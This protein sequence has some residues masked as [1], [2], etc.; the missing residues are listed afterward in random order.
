MDRFQKLFI[1]V[2]TLVVLI[3]LAILVGGKIYS[4]WGRTLVY[5]RE[6]KITKYPG[7]GD[8]TEKLDE[9]IFV[10]P[11]F[12]GRPYSDEGRPFLL[13]LKTGISTLRINI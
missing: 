11:K 9:R 4:Y 13:R 10:E 8:V 5:P 3:G 1:F 12:F 2:L 6:S 7:S